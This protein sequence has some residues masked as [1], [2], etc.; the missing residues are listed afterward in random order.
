MVDK[1][2]YI[3]MDGK[4]VSWDDAKVHVLTHSLHYATAP[5]EGIRCYETHDG[6]AAIFRLNEH[7]R[8]L[9]DS[10]K[11]LLMEIPFSFQSIADAC[12]ELLAANGMKE[13]YLRPIVFIGEGAMGVH[14]RNNPIRVCIAAWKWGAYLGDE[15]A[16]KGARLK[17]SSYARYGV[18]TVMTK[19]KVSGNYVTSVLAKREAVA[20]GFDEALML[21]TEGYIAEGSGENVFM[22]RNG[23]I[24]TTPLTSILPGITRETVIQVARDFGYEVVEQRFSRDELYVAD[25]AFFTGTAVEVTAIREVDWRQIGEGKPGPIT[26]KIRSTFNDVIRGKNKKY[27]SW[28]TYV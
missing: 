19:A 17:V 22:V 3:W 18:N 16:Q 1:V 26:T 11:I 8:R 14:P 21:D 23:R 15:A 25:E 28:L 27:E 7:V 5:F 12:K 10:C 9:Y 24:K 20:L 6:K 4:L 13:A 2:K